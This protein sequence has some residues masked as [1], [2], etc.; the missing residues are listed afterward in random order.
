[1]AGYP[2]PF[3][4]PYYGGYGRPLMP[5]NPNVSLICILQLCAFDIQV[6]AT[7]TIHIFQDAIREIKQLEKAAEYTPEVERA[8][9][10]YGY[11]ISICNSL[12]FSHRAAELHC[13]R[14]DIELKYGHRYLQAAIED[15]DESI[16]KDPDHLIV[17][18]TIYMELCVSIVMHGRI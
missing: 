7:Y 1:M 17:C 15:V 2:W 8:I 3:Q 6:S 4:S 16:E 11:A 12:N 14:A 13:K 9:D 5:T 10:L 18:D